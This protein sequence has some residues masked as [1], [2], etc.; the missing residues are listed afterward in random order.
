[1]FQPYWS[2]R[3]LNCCCSIRLFSTLF[4]NLVRLGKQVTLQFTE[5]STWSSSKS[6]KS[7]EHEDIR[8]I[9][10]SVFQA[11]G[12]STGVRHERQ[13]VSSTVSPFLRN[14]FSNTILADLTEWS[15]Y[16]K[17]RLHTWESRPASINHKTCS[18]EIHLI[19][20]SEKTRFLHVPTSLPSNQSSKSMSISFKDL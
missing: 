20:N 19:Q 18:G 17:P 2:T 4:L 8:I 12:S 16:G 3:I 6:K 7:I 14:F 13:G 15:I 11:M 1:M 10:V 9:K 5:L